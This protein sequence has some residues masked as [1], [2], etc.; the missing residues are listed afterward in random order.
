MSENT[1]PANE[2]APQP[3]ATNQDNA[4]A[5]STPV[6]EATSTLSA[7]AAPK[8]EDSQPAKKE[9]KQG[10]RDTRTNKTPENSD[11]PESD[12][13][14]VNKGDDNKDDQKEK[15][16]NHSQQNKN[17]QNNANNNRRGRRGRKANEPN[18]N[19]S[20]V[21]QKPIR[22]DAKAVSK[23]AWKIFLAEVGEEGL[24]LI[25]DK[26]GKELTKRSFRLSEIF[27]EEEQRRIKLAKKK[28]NPEGSKRLSLLNRSNQERRRQPKKQRS[29]KRLSQCLTLKSQ[30]RR[31]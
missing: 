31:M 9:P 29:L 25:G 14:A 22:L 2:A 1:S 30:K 16:G 17:Q 15:D 24:A 23:K 18:P 26:E 8:S 11:Q 12:S 28:A 19:Q 5:K 3:A 7:S 21:K 6:T 27:Q 10:V 13:K 4:S 20:Q